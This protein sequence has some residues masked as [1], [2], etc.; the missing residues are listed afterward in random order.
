MEILDRRWALV[1][2]LV[3]A[4]LPSQILWSSLILK[5]AAVWAALSGLA[6]VVA[7][8]SRAE[9]RR[10]LLLGAA[11]AALLTLLGFLRLYTLEI[12]CVAIVLAVLAGP[13]P[14]SLPRIG[15]AVVL[16][17]CI[18]LAFGMGLAGGRFVTATPDPREQRALNAA[19]GASAVAA[20]RARADQ[21]SPA[22]ANLA[23]LPTGIAVVAL[24]P[25]PWEQSDTSLGVRMAR[26]ETI[27]W[28]PLLLLAL[29]GFASVWAHRRALAFPLFAGGGI[30]LVYALTEGNLGT[31]YRH[32]GEFVWVVALLATLGAERI[33]AWRSARQRMVAT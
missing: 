8:S 22:G 14:R 18:P 5:D 25:W 19:Q 21:Q 33:C 15:G 13:R 20:A 7:L 17:A 10:L 1:A 2:G 4:L 9:G 27:L 23:Y 26:A 24:R 11:A 29:L 28:Y 30:L 6:V 31:A 12:A 3:V 32:R 16:L